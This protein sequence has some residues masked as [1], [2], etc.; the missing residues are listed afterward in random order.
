MPPYGK[1]VVALM[2]RMQW[3]PMRTYPRNTRLVSPWRKAKLYKVNSGFEILDV[4]NHIKWGMIN[5]S[6]SKQLKESSKDSPRKTFSSRNVQK[7]NA[8]LHPQV[9]YLGKERRMTN[10]WGIRNNS[11]AGES[12]TDQGN[13]TSVTRH[14]QVFSET[15]VEEDAD[16]SI[17]G[18]KNVLCIGGD[19]VENWP[20]FN[21]QIKIESLDNSKPL[22]VRHS[23]KNA[24]PNPQEN[25]RAHHRLSGFQAAMNKVNSSLL[26]FNPQNEIK[27]IHRFSRYLA[28]NLQT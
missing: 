26:Y 2:F 1:W 17:I 14:H 28:D 15:I 20:S 13:P 6:L 22:I 16:N 23:N 9:T 8:P 21:T 24:C 12:N 19:L 25:K 18:K 5:T 7:A 10:S 3:T 27:R 11:L 4:K